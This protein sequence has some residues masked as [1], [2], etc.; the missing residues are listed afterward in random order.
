M[1]TFKYICTEKARGSDNFLKFIG[2]T[3]EFFKKNFDSQIEICFCVTHNYSRGQGGKK[4][5]ILRF[6]KEF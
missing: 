6:S 3:I 5:K 4:V 1:P 2:G